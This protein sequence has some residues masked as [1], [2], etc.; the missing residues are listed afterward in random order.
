MPRKQTSSSL[1]RRRFLQRSA[2]GAAMLAAPAVL[3]ARAPSDK[4][5]IVIIGCGGRGASN[6][7]EMLTENTAGRKAII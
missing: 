6:M 2:A 4:L 5:N 1:T 7:K 3:S